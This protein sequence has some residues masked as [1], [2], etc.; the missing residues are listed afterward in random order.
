MYQGMED[1]IKQAFSGDRNALSQDIARGNYELLSEDG[2]IVLPIVWENLVQPGWKVKMQMKN[3]QPE[4][5]EMNHGDTD[6]ANAE[7][8]HTPENEKD[9]QP[10]SYQAVAVEASS[11]EED[12]APNPRREDEDV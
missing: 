4:N 8:S 7:G 1:L 3:T 5:K 10:K 11:S 12:I 9:N 6:T 2:S